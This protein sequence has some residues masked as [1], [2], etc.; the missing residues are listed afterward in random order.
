MHKCLS[1]RAQTVHDKRLACNVFNLEPQEQQFTLFTTCWFGTWRPISDF[2]R[3]ATFYWLLREG[4]RLA[5]RTRSTVNVVQTR[6]I[7]IL[8]TEATGTNGRE[9]V[10]PLSDEGVK[11][12][13]GDGSFR[14]S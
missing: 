6:G 12:R 11:I 1:G 5:S 7:M 2:G 10:K 4:I 9:T 3:R 14:H 8:V 13:V